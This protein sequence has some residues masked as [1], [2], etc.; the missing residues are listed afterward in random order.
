MLL[1]VAMC[2][3]QHA[4][5]IFTL[6]NRL[7]HCQGLILKSALYAMHVNI[8]VVH[9]VKHVVSAFCRYA[10]NWFVHIG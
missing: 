3:A 6:A 5:P 7:A 8:P 9:V 1:F 10:T 2:I 4:L